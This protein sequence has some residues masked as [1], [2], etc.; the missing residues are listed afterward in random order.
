MCRCSKMRLL[1]IYAHRRTPCTLIS[2]RHTPMGKHIPDICYGNPGEKAKKPSKPP[3]ST[4]RPG[5]NV[6]AKP[7]A[8][9]SPIKNVWAKSASIQPIA[10]IPPITSIRATKQRNNPPMNLPTNLP[11]GIFSRVKSNLLCPTAAIRSNHCTATFIAW[12]FVFLDA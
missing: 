7:C 10:S 6:P 11:V 3:Y 1:L 9:H 12:L 4:S 5:A 2:V 8:S